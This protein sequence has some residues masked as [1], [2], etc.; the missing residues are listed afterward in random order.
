MISPMT[1]SNM[2]S[3]EG[4]FLMP[5]PAMIGEHASSARIMSCV[6]LA[7][8]KQTREPAVEM[9]CSSNALR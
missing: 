6:G 4:A 9:P 2:P 3:P 7:A 8:Q 1:T 5:L